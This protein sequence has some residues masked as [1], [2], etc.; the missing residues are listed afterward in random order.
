LDVIGLVAAV[1]G[2]GAFMVSIPERSLLTVAAMQAVLATPAL[3]Q[4]ASI[5]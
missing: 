4:P 3:A 1:A 5:S 2:D